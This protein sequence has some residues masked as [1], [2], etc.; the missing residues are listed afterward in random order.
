M[1]NY[2]SVYRI[3]NVF[4]ITFGSSKRN[5]LVYCPFTQHDKDDHVVLPYVSVDL[6]YTL[7]V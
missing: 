5:R 3:S 6:L 1:L 2:L 4:I 7:H